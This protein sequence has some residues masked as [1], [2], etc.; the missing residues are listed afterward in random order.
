MDDKNRNHGNTAQFGL[1]HLHK[2][3]F[4]IFPELLLEYNGV[5][6]T[7]KKLR[8]KCQNTASTALACFMSKYSQYCTRLFSCQNTASTGLHSIIFMS[9]YSQYYTRLFLCQNTA[10]SVLDYVHVKIQPVL[11]LIIFMSNYS[12]YYTRLF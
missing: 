12:Q 4:I 8:T 9:K 7:L 2:V 5:A 1:F 11:H 10:S 6:R 3:F